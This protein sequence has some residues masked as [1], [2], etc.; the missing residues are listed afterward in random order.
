M[1]IDNEPLQ[2]FLHGQLDARARSDARAHFADCAECRDR[3]AAAEREEAALASLLGHLDHTPRPTSAHA[4][5]R[6][7]ALRQ[8]DAFRRAAATILLTLG[9]AATV[10]ALPASRN[11]IV[12]RFGSNPQRVESG[13]PAPQPTTSPAI[14]GIGVP[15]GT[16]LVIE[17][18]APQAAGHADIVFSD[19]GE[20]IRIRTV[21][22]AVFDVVAD[23]RVSIQNRG[24]TAD[25]EIAIPRAAPYVEVRVGEVRIFLKE[26]ASITAGEAARTDGS[27]TLPLSVRA[28]AGF[29]AS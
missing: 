21:G 7:A 13:S 22:Q 28:R 15:F 8:R 9:T 19:E 1:H 2:R 27:Y 24:S 6:E 14:S 5:L 18:A 23:D 17:F 29:A 3:L 16:R 12:D 11:W 20:E 4:L 26:G 10:W 25:F